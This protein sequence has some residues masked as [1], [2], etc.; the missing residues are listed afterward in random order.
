MNPTKANSTRR[1]NSRLPDVL[2]FEDRMKLATAHYNCGSVGFAINEAEEEEEHELMDAY[3]V[4]RRR[5]QCTSGDLRLI[6]D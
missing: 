5:T 3:R 6:S 1:V 4:P 2:S